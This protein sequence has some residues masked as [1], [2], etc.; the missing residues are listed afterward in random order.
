MGNDAS[1]PTC[2]GRGRITDDSG[3][4][5]GMLAGGLVGAVIA[6]PV[7]GLVGCIV[8]G[9]SQIQD[10]P[11][12]RCGGTGKLNGGADRPTRARTPRGWH[13]RSGKTLTMYHGTSS[14]NAASITASGFRPSS[15]GMLGAG[16]YLSADRS[17]A[18]QYGNT[19]LEVEVRIGKTK[20][21]DCQNH[22]MQ[23]SWHQHGY[24]SAWVPPGCGMVRSNR[25]ETCVF[26]PKRIRVV[27]TS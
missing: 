6:G 21:I 7:G 22:P 17:K 23:T 5:G 2:E 16:V 18:A 1:C 8:G 3:A 15:D 9:A 4:T 25:T 13:G 11:C 26:D 19:V 14:A 12:G 27:S 10:K 20:K 24:D